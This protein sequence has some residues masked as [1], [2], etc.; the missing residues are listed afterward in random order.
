[1]A[2]GL[3][4][5]G[6]A[7]IGTAGGFNP[8]TTAEWVRWD[9][10]NYLSIANHGYTLMSCQGEVFSLCGNSGWFPFYPLLIAPFAAVGLQAA[11]VGLVISLVF[12]PRRSCCC[13]TRF[14]EPSR[15]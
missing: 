5:A 14:S 9:S 10:R 6:L 1:M 7:A 8:F 13:G 4:C 11:T 2:F 3:A 12:A 15:H